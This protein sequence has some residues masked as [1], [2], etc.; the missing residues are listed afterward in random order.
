MI[1][2]AVGCSQ[3]EGCKFWETG[4]KGAASDS[5]GGGSQRKGWL[6]GWTPR[7]NA[8]LPA[9]TEVKYCPHPTRIRDAVRRTR[10]RAGT[11]RGPRRPRPNSCSLSTRLHDRR[12]G[13]IR[14][15]VV[16]KRKPLGPAVMVC[17]LGGG[18]IRR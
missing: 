10:E 7:G 11:G 4:G 15:F 3:V 8:P 14:A 13:Q 17:A 9:A 1:K 5:G 12:F 18:F 2:Q 6:L 16:S